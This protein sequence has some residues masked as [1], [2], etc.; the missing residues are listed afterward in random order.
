[1]K[2]FRSSTSRAAAIAVAAL[3]G[4]VAGTAVTAEAGPS[5]SHSFTTLTL[6]NGWTGSP[7]GTRSPAV[8]LINGVVVFKGAMAS[9]KTNPVAFTL[10]KAFRPSKAVFVTVDLS[11]TNLGRLQIEPSGS[12]SVQA[13]NNAFANASSFTSLD[14]V[15]FA[16]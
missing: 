10:P 12:V 13:E 2:R 3:I 1:M 8:S 7:F 11:N 4:A 14:G 9:V 6:Q 16:K 15:S 5:V